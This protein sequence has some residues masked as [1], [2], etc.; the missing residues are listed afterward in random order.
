MALTERFTV[1]GEKGTPRAE[2]NVVPVRAM[3]VFR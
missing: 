1:L 2:A 3:I